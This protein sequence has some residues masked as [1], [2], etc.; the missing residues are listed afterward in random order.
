MSAKFP[1]GGS[2]V[3]FGRQ[4]ISLSSQCIRW[5]C[6]RLKCALEEQEMIYRKIVNIGTSEIVDVIILKIEQGVVFFA[7]NNAF[8]RYLI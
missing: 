3:F 6:I 1:R 4:S 8:K 7:Y 5:Q 2:R